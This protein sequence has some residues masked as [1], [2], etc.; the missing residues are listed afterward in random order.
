MCGVHY[1][2]SVLCCI[3]LNPKRNP[4]IPQA[5]TINHMQTIFLERGSSV[6]V[7]CRP[8]SSSVEVECRPHSSRGAH[9]LRWNADHIPREGLFSW[10][11]MWCSSNDFLSIWRSDSK[12]FT[13]V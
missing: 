8:H 6:E 9:Q 11:G 3:K 4:T 2:L 7:E 1:V 10:G 13:L 5:Q 12:W